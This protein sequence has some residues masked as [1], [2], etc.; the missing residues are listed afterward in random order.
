MTPREG[1]F[2]SPCGASAFSSGGDQFRQCYHFVGDDVRFVQGRQ[3]EHDHDRGGAFPGVEHNHRPT[4]KSRLARIECQTSK[5][6]L[7]GAAALLT[8]P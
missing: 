6:L 2:G 3:P 8:P 7:P 4:L 5:H 1:P